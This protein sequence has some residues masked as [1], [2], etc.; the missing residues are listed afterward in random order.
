MKRALDLL[1]EPGDIVQGKP[2]PEITEIAGSY[3]ECLR[4]GGG[5]P[6]RQPAAQRLVD[7]L[8]KGAARRGA[9]PP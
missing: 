9:I 3:P 7:D 2:W 1:H 4:L 8:A 6:A 5:A